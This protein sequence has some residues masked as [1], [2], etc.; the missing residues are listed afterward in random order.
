MAENV[1]KKKIEFLK[2]R[3]AVSEA[4][5]TGCL[6]QKPGLPGPASVTPALGVLTGCQAWQWAQGVAPVDGTLLRWC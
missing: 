3:P 2:S 6:L 5:G 1:Y 4:E